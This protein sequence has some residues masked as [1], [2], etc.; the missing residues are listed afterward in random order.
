ML[1]RR[2]A[3]IAILMLTGFVVLSIGGWSLAFNGSS[4]SV[5]ASNAHWW[6]QRLPMLVG[7]LL[8]V[9]GFRV[10]SRTRV[11]RPVDEAEYEEPTP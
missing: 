3:A 10:L 5:P 9:T 8:L 7:V 1:T 11:A 2:I 4:S 6:L